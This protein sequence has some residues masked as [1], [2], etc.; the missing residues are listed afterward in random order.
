MS[1]T[2]QK[3]TRT[4]RPF[5]AQASNLTG[6]IDRLEQE[7]ANLRL[8]LG[9]FAR[10]LLVISDLKPGTYGTR[11]DHRRHR[12]TA[13]WTTRMTIKI[14]GYSDGTV[15]MGNPGGKPTK[16][17]RRDSTAMIL[18]RESVAREKAQAAEV[19]RL[20]AALADAESCANAAS[21]LF[22]AWVKSEEPRPTRCAE[23]PILSKAVADYDYSRRS[24]ALSPE[25]GKQ[26]KV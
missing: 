23:W 2:V 15:E 6:E 11:H 5:L 17:Q 25:D 12:R 26:E 10:E 14:T 4:L 22:R 18:L 21:D 16:S 24:L 3:F 19:T 20:T 1:E 9:E 13:C 7:I 8:V